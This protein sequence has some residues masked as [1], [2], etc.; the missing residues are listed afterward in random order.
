MIHCSNDSPS[1]Q[2]EPTKVV[3][4]SPDTWS[5]AWFGVKSSRSHQA[6]HKWWFY[7]CLV[8]IMMGFDLVPLP[9]KRCSTAAMTAPTTK[10]SPPTLLKQH[11]NTGSG[12]WL[13]VKSSWSHQAIHKWWC[14]RCLVFMMMVFDWTSSGVISTPWWQ[15]ND[16]YGCSIGGWG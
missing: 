4:N 12:A 15:S 16:Y 9:Q 10:A 14:C 3:N 7:R 8:F 11:P 5:K 13:G 2:S 1:N 6:I